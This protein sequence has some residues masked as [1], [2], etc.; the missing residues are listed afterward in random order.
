M[1][2][3]RLRSNQDPGRYEGTH[4]A[5]LV[6]LVHRPHP[7]AETDCGLG[8]CSDESF[9]RLAHLLPLFFRLPDCL[10]DLDRDRLT[11][12]NIRRVIEK[13]LK[14]KQHCETLNRVDEEDKIEEMESE[15]GRLIVGLDPRV[16][17]TSS[18]KSG[19]SYPAKRCPFLIIGI[20]GTAPLCSVT[21]NALRLLASQEDVTDI[22][23]LYH[24]C[25]NPL[26]PDS[27]QLVAQLDTTSVKFGARSD[28]V[29][30]GVEV[31]STMPPEAL[32]RSLGFTDNI[33]LLFNSHRHKGG[34]TPW[35]NTS[36]FQDV[37]SEEI[38]RFELRWHQLA[39]THAILRRLLSREPNLSSESP[40]ILVADEVGLGKTLQALAVLAWLIEMV[41][42]Q[43]VSAAVPPILGKPFT[44]YLR[45][46]L[47]FVLPT[48]RYPYF[49]ESKIIP[50]LP[51]LIIIPGTILKQWESEIKTALNPKAFDLFIYKT[52]KDFRLKFWSKTGPFALSNQPAANKIILATHSVR[53]YCISHLLRL[54]CFR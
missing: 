1:F 33:P 38:V 37:H 29:D 8:N 18:K 53:I 20:I 48:G 50:N 10:A 46:V 19:K 13:V 32:S 3:W 39:G 42:R 52:G 40:G 4:S 34:V 30:P 51:H 12:A 41:G 47:Q 25:F 43:S 35:D 49:G 6:R 11:E 24:D 21:K 27:S 28:G 7:F 14:W 45:S 22:V 5:H 36:A 9:S 44:A 54:T 17:P 2:C 23:N 16:K 31:E 26:A 15:L